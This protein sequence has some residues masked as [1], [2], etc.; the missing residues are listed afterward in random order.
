MTFTVSNG[1]SLLAM[2][3]SISM[4]SVA[5]NMTE[6][7]GSLAV[8]D[9]LE[10]DGTRLRGTYGDAT[11][12]ISAV[13]MILSVIV[14]VHYIIKWIK[15]RQKTSTTKTF[16]HI[17]W[18]IFVVALLSSVI[19]GI[20]NIILFENYE[21]MVNDG[22]IKLSGS[23]DFGSETA[24][25]KLRG[26]YGNGILA[27]NAVTV[28]ASGIAFATVFAGLF[29]HVPGVSEHGHHSRSHNSDWSDALKDL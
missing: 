5:L 29:T 12:A 14:L 22:H 13:A 25:L 2:A 16:G 9:H 23:V 20:M 24:D 28:A 10:V 21:N 26:S 11:L 27:M 4:S 7:Y 3:S 19:T 17:F 18:F 6:N 8:K 1:L 15:N